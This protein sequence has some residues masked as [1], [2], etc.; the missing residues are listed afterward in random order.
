MNIH[1]WIQMGFDNGWCTPSV[2]STHDE[3]PLTDEEEKMW[4][5]GSDPCVHVLRLCLDKEEQTTV[6]HN[7]EWL[8][9]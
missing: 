2:C 5:D 9:R 6:L 8:T 3:V 4:E 1:E 7:N